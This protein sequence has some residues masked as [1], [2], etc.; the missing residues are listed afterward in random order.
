MKW[1]VYI[2]FVLLAVRHIW[3]RS[4]RS[5]MFLFG[6]RTFKLS[7]NLVFR[8]V[9]CNETFD[10]HARLIMIVPLIPG[11]WD[12][13]KGNLIEAL[14]SSYDNRLPTWID[15]DIMSDL[16]YSLERRHMSS[17]DA[18]YK[19]VNKTTQYELDD[20]RS[21]FTKIGKAY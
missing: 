5:F 1:I 2:G 7:F 15:F 12:Y 8:D 14:H 3:Q 18:L 10:G 20:M 19:I 6:K 9:T 4:R 11:I 16:V 17:C 21:V 13:T